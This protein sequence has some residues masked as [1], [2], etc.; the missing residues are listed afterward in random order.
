MAAHRFVN[1]LFFSFSFAYLST[2]SVF[3]QKQLSYNGADILLDIQKLKVNGAVLYIAAH[4]DDE[5]TRL[6]TYFSKEKLYRTAYLS[7][8]N[9]GG[10]QNLIGDEQGAALGMIR[11]EELLAARRIDGA[12]QF[13]ANADDFGYSKSKEETLQKW[14]KNKLLEQIVRIIRSFKPNIIITRFPPDKRAGHG[15][16]AASALLAAEAFD[17]AADSNSFIHHFKEGLLPWHTTSLFWNTYN[18]GSANTIAPNQMKIDVGG[19]NALLGKN[20]GEIAAESRSQHKSQGFGSAGQRGTQLEYFSF[21]KGD[22]SVSLTDECSF[23]LKQNKKFQRKW[24]AKI[25][26]IIDHYKPANPAAS[27]PDLISLYKYLDNNDTDT[28]KLS[29]IR[30]I[31][32]K[33]SGLFAEASSQKEYAVCGDSLMIN[34]TLLNRSLLKIKLQSVSIVGA[35]FIETGK[36]SILNHNILYR[37]TIPMIVPSAHEVLIYKGLAVRFEILIEDFSLSIIRPL[38]YKFSDPVKGELIWPLTFY[39]AFTLSSLQKVCLIDQN[40]DEIPLRF[41]IHKYTIRKSDSM[42]I[43]LYARNKMGDYFLKSF[44]LDTVLHE[45]GKVNILVSSKLLKGATSFYI[46]HNEDVFDQSIQNI[47][48]D[49]IPAL[50]LFEKVSIIFQ[51]IKLNIKGE[52]VGYINGAGDWV[53]EAIRLLGYQVDFLRKEDI[54]FEILRKYDAVVMGIRAYNLHDWLADKH[55]VFMQYADS[56]GVMLIQYNTSSQVGPLKN[57]RWL[58]PFTISRNRVSEEDAK[59]TFLEKD[60]SIFHFPNIITDADFEYWVQER[61]VYEVDSLGLSC[62]ALIAMHD[63]DEPDRKGSLVIEERGK[64]RLIYTGLSF[65]RQLPAGVPGAFRLLANLL[66]NP[67]KH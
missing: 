64:G 23:T 25:D 38:Q 44:S 2:H 8:T 46:K 58:F 17:L 37:D 36:K 65:F 12:E 15:H 4:P 41:Q 18:F 43:S 9:G 29:F 30:Q 53:A 28:F 20:Y 11:S 19:Y 5:N 57:N 35:V 52:K 39:P 60:H 33:A 48:Y 63:T 16:H 7:L 42:T 54:S 45:D 26:H 24:N 32:I 6:L 51:E 3:A 50:V 55:H 40:K 10:G 27:V 59:V 21:V 66:A 61:S 31:I 49:H 13:F 62:K 34:T 22:S 67:L 14:D 56:G 1:F 47:K